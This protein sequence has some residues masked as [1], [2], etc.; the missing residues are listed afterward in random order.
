MYKITLLTIFSLIFVV[1]A[2]AQ[3]VP[4]APA[5][6]TIESMGNYAHLNWQ[7]SA[8]ANGYKIYKALNTFP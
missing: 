8:G 2:S 1:F 5:N 3:T 6:L 4:P 7:P